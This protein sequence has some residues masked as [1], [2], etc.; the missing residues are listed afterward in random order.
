MALTE[1]EIEMTEG[2]KKEL[3]RT[4]RCGCV[5][6]A[7]FEHFTGGRVWHSVQIGRYYQTKHGDDRE[8]STYAPAELAQ[9]ARV[10]V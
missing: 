9:V 1:G 2:K 7:V 5:E 8:A 4:I 10:E 3:V 6:A